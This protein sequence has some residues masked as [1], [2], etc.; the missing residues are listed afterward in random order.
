[1]KRLCKMEPYYIIPRV[2]YIYAGYTGL[3]NGLAIGWLGRM[4][5]MVI[6]INERE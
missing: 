4:F 5:I 2:F 6:P 1:M 3:D